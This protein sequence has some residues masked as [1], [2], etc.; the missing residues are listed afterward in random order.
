MENKRKQTEIQFCSS[1]FVHGFSCNDEIKIFKKN[2]LVSLSVSK[3]S[4]KICTNSSS[5]LKYIHLKLLFHYMEGIF[6]CKIC[7]ISTTGSTLSWAIKICT[8]E[9]VPLVLLIQILQNHVCSYCRKQVQQHFGWSQLPSQVITC[10]L[11]CTKYNT[12]IKHCNT[13][14]NLKPL[15]IKY[16]L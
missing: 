6:L 8:P 10:T 4:Q 2:S 15:N 16:L 12:V 5:S 11:C 3:P 14:I 13:A 7:P 9:L 1:S